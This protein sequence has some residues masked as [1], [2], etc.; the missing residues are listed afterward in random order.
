MFDPD[1]SLLKNYNKENPHAKI[2]DW[3][4]TFLPNK[5]GMFKAQKSSAVVIPPRA[6]DRLDFL[7]QGLF[8]KL[9]N[10]SLD[11]R[12]KLLK[13]IEDLKL[14]LQSSDSIDQLCSIIS[15]F[16]PPGPESLYVTEHVGSHLVESSVG[17]DPKRVLSGQTFVSI[18]S[19]LGQLEKEALA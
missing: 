2:P 14:N 19:H 9:E 7:F 3:E 15:D 13:Q 4:D 1:P 17:E 8:T 16:P 12:E 18:K 11:D 5:V 10:K 6:Q